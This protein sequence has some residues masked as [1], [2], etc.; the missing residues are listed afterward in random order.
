MTSEIEKVMARDDPGDYFVGSFLQ[1]EMD[2]RGWRTG[3]VAIRMPHTSPR[4]WAINYLAVDL[5]LAVPE[6]GA[7][8]DAALAAD[9]GR[10]FGLS[11]E[12]FLNISR[13]CTEY[14][15][16]LKAA[17]LLADSPNDQ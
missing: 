5:L 4:E 13:F 15:A 1:E 11:P 9:L 10:A 12:F 14:R 3:D 16:M 8:I 2:A 17:A 6:S 7:A